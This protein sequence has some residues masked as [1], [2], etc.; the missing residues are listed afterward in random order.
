MSTDTTTTVGPGATATVDAPV[1]APALSNGAGPLPPAPRGGRFVALEHR[2]Y[3][4]YWFG[5][6]VSLLGTQMSSVAI[7][8]QIYQLTHDPLML[9]L[10][11]LFTVVPL[12]VFSL[13]GGVVADALDRR[14]LLLLTQVIFLGL[15][16]VLAVTT[17][18][19]WVSVWVIFGVAVVQG[20]VQAFN[21]P[22]R[23]ALIPNLVPREHVTN[24]ISLGVTSWQAAAVVG[25]AL[26]GN[27]IGFATNALGA[28]GVG[29]VYVID[30][31]SF[32]AVLA[33]LGA[34]RTRTQEAETR[35][36]SI[37]AAVEGLRFVFRSPIMMGTM[38]LDFFAT[39]FG[40]SM[41]LMPVFATD[42]FHVGASGLGYLLAAPS[43]GAVVTAVGLSFFGHVRRQGRVVL[44]SV[45]AYGLAWVVFGLSNNFWLALLALAGTGASDT[46]SMVMRQTIRQLSTP[47][48]LRGRMT[49]VNMIFFMGGPQLGEFE[50]GLV[51][52]L[53]SAPWA[54]LIG[55]MGVLVV[56]GLVAFF[57]PTVRDYEA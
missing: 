29:V 51:A 46:V 12:V 50:G 39:F 35:T 3:R 13:Y 14:R 36:V 47:D 30:A 32:L 45:A 52:R 34:M 7:G 37:A 53:F 24:A 44:W 16:S 38:L 21:N 2:D 56:T 26:A 25:P 43:A 41:L 5:N 33:A 17:L 48:A 40:A 28:R 15:S 18:T 6:L 8:W 4:L 22:A 55:G 19:G 1:D 9:G 10:L 57:V 23:S 49:S 27:I 42:V 20:A 31:I 11:G 54:A